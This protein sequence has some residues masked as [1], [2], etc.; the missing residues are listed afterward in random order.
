MSI[1]KRR[2][3]AAAIA[4]AVAGLVLSGCAGAGGGGEAGTDGEGGAITVLMVGNPQM[5]DIQQITE[6][7]FTADTGIVAPPLIAEKEHIDEIV[8]MLREKL[9]EI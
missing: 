1:T 2:L 6:D 4:P 3:A 7:T 8:E 5:Q 9:A